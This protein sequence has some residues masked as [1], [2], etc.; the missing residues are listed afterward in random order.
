MDQSLN[1]LNSSYV[2]N[3]TISSQVPKAIKLK[4]ITISTPRSCIIPNYSVIISQHVKRFEKFT[5]KCLK[6]LQVFVHIHKCFSDFE[7]DLKGKGK[8]IVHLKCNL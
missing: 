5:Q 8:K 2:R 1:I 4:N 7:C 3:S 6:C